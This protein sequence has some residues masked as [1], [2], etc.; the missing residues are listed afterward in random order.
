MFREKTIPRLAL[1]LFDLIAS[2]LFESDGGKEYDR[3]QLHQS[4]DEEHGSLT[5]RELGDA[6]AEDQV[7][8]TR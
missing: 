7:K 2:V 1:T 6:H 3:S 8:S 4:C 5:R